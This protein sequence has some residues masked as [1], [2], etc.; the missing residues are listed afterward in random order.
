MTSK[1]IYKNNERRAAS[2]GCILG[3]TPTCARAF[4][5]SSPSKQL[6]CLFLHLGLLL[7]FKEML[8]LLKLY[9]LEIEFD[10][11]NERRE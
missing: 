8:G 5:V 2:Q 3:A 6:Y 9:F 10:F 7:H 1:G 11:A 4:M